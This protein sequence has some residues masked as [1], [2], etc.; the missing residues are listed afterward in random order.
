MQPASSYLRSTIVLSSVRALAL[1]LALFLG[2]LSAAYYGT[3]T[4]KDC[5]LIAQAIPTLLT[6]LIIGGVYSSLMLSLAETGNAHG[7]AG[8][9]T[10]VRRTVA[11]LTILLAPLILV[12]VLKPE[13]IMRLI[14]PGFAPPQIALSSSLLR[15]TML[16]MAGMV[17]F[18][19]IK[20]MFDSWH[21]FA[22]PGLV[23]L[24]VG[25]SSIAAILA[26]LETRQD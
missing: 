15:I 7:G 11:R 26:F 14:A 13:P 18:A 8:Q 17:L 12:A 10:H 25:A 19:M 20:A 1:A 5:Y 6:T 9:L 23:H 2:M 3:S 21:R 16:T 4:E 24:L 22:V